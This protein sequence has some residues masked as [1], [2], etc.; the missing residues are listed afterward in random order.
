MKF[1]S[2]VIVAVLSFGL[3]VFFTDTGSGEIK[4]TLPDYVNEEPTKPSTSYTTYYDQ[5]NSYQKSIYNAILNGISKGAKS[6]EFKDVNYNDFKN[7]CYKASMAVEYDHPEYF[8][9][10]GGYSHTS[11][12]YRF[13]ENTTIEFEFLYYEYANAMFDFDEKAGRLNQEVK[14]VADLARSYSSD[15]YER[16]LFVHDYLIENAYYDMEW[17]EEYYK[18]SHNPSCEYIFS[19]YGCLVEGRT[20]CSGYAKAFQL[21]L[22]ELGYDCIY[23]TGDAGEPHGWN[24]VYIEDEGY[25]VDVTWD[26][27]DLEDEVPMYNY[28][29]IDS[30]ALGRNHTIDNDFTVPVCNADKYNFYKNRGYYIEKYDFSEAKAILTAQS[31]NDAAYI[32]FG[33]LEELGNAYYDL[34]YGAKYKL[35]KG[36][37]SFDD[38]EYDEDQRTL[39]FIK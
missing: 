7:N 21:I 19:A 25:F 10:T 20:V 13:Q 33:S 37:G 1:L 29:F 39:T 38:F 8:W 30:E 4:G 16:M 35:V 32:Q 17:L 24:C 36:L 28:A 34:V 5:L 31:G 6:I 23:V 11:Y 2:Y 27:M 22:N 15:D 12:K 14:R 3:A 26:D 18:T 9:Y